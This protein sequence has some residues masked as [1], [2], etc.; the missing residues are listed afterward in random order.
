MLSDSELLTQ[1]IIYLHFVQITNKS[2]EIII[3]SYRE[4]FF[5]PL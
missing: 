1:R 4:A 3:Y 2:N 5:F